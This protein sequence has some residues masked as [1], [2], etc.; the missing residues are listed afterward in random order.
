MWPFEC[1]A[2][3]RG[4]VGVKREKKGRKEGREGREG[5]KEKERRKERERQREREDQD[6]SIATPLTF[7]LV[8]EKG[9]PVWRIIG[10]LA[11]SRLLKLVV[12]HSHQP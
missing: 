4:Q 7:G 12:R 9:G 10:Y 1:Y 11:V 5:K 8:V 3:C 2:F 6:F